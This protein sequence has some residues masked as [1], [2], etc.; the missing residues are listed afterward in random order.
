[1]KEKRIC[2][3]T[4][5]EIITAVIEGINSGVLMEDG[6]VRKYD[7]FDYYELTHESIYDLLSITKGS[8]NNGKAVANLYK[9]IR[10]QVGTED[11][12]EY[13]SDLARDMNEKA[14]NDFIE[15]KISRYQIGEN[16]EF[17]AC[18]EI[19]MEEK[20]QVIDFV[21]NEGIPFT[22]CLGNRA[23][24]RIVNNIPLGVS[25]VR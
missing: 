21:N 10:K 19:T 7:I 6:R 20:L 13:S 18:R 14:I 15:E 1:M 17:G 4:D 24:D 23:I 11:K 25:K 9:W 22:E 8:I 2:A 5:L 3:E 12:S 16:G